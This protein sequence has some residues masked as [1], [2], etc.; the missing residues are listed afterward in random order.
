MAL[1]PSEGSDP[2]SDSGTEYNSKKVPN[3]SGPTDK[4]PKGVMLDLGALRRN[5]APWLGRASFPNTEGAFNYLVEQ[6][7]ER[8]QMT[9][10]SDFIYN[11]R[12]HVPE[13]QWSLNLRRLLA[14]AEASWNTIQLVEEVLVPHER[15]RSPDSVEDEPTPAKVPKLGQ[16]TSSSVAALHIRGPLLMD[17]HCDEKLTVDLECDEVLR[18]PTGEVVA[19]PTGPHICVVCNKL[20]KRHVFNTRQQVLDAVHQRDPYLECASYACDHCGVYGLLNHAC[21][22]CGHRIGVYCRTC[23]RCYT[24]VDNAD[25]IEH[26]AFANESCPSCLGLSDDLV[27]GINEESHLRR[28]Y[29]ECSGFAVCMPRVRLSRVE[30]TGEYVR[31]ADRPLVNV[32]AITDNIIFGAG[33]GML[34]VNP[35]IHFI[36]DVFNGRNIHIVEADVNT[37]LGMTV[38]QALALLHRTRHTPDHMG[39]RMALLRGA[40]PGMEMGEVH[41]QLAEFFLTGALMAIQTAMIED[42]SAIHHEAPA[43][44]TA[45]RTEIFAYMSRVLGIRVRTED[46]FINT[47]RLCTHMVR[48][49]GR[50]RHGF[51]DMSDRLIDYIALHPELGMTSTDTFQSTGD[52]DNTIPASLLSNDVYMTYETHRSAMAMREHDATLHYIANWH[53]MRR[54]GFVRPVHYAS[55]VQQLTA[56][57]AAMQS[58]VNSIMDE[59][60]N[61]VS[62]DDVAYVSSSGASDV[63]DEGDPNTQPTAAYYLNHPDPALQRYGVWLQRQIDGYY[64]NGYAGLPFCI[65]SDI[66]YSVPAPLH[67]TASVAAPVPVAVPAPARRNPEDYTRAEMA[68]MVI[69]NRAGFLAALYRR[70]RAERVLAAAP[71]YVDTGARTAIIDAIEFM[72]A[73]EHDNVDLVH[74][75]I[76]DV[77][78]ED[79][80]EASCEA[81]SEEANEVVTSSEAASDSDSDWSAGDDEEEDE[82]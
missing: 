24:E 2:G 81:S 19:I 25:F 54:Q 50:L 76:R 74:L 26:C 67:L 44:G 47:H 46:D 56:F 8:E 36:E 40:Y 55:H 60:G 4:S 30:A 41:V 61:Y 10:I 29:D 32:P 17:L 21:G 9:V 35:N 64:N 39:D 12:N 38:Q 78:L 11:V 33:S 23:Y 22:G 20:H 77:D 42:I 62:D 58:P 75:E 70:E 57:T 43:E 7:F 68:D 82:E 31:I 80:R 27:N 1:N 65:E 79:A 59:E 6:G 37:R 51:Q 52:W 15:G 28:A 3:T 16:E 53:I 72:T 66:D 71:G 49:L 45:R 5:A 63:T 14:H 69:G 13:E 48:V 34:F 18:D 73:L